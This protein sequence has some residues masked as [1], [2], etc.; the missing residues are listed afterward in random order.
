MRTIPGAQGTRRGGPP[1]ASPR[2]ALRR[3]PHHI[4]VA[5]LALVLAVACVPLRPVRSS[6]LAS[7][8]PLAPSAAPVTISA[9]GDPAGARQI[10]IVEV[11]GQQPGATLVDL[12]DEFGARVARM[13]GDHGRIDSIATRRETSIERHQYDCS[14]EE[15]EV[16]TQVDWSTGPGGMPTANVVSVPVARRV[17]KMCIEERPVEVATTTL[18]GRAFRTGGRGR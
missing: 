10:G 14:T 1:G 12:V 16:Q 7:E 11:T 15:V 8:A 3:G 9:T 2:S 18:L 5:A 17:F 6:A 4:L 13:G